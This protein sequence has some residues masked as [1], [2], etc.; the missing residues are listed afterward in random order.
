MVLT[1][2]DLAQ[3]EGITERVVTRITANL[4]TKAE[5]SDL[6]TKADLSDLVTKAELSKLATKS[7]LAAAF[8]ALGG[9]IDNLKSMLEDDQRTESQRLSRVD[10]R[11]RRLRSEFNQHV[12]AN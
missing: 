1:E 4:A 7:E 10:R 9:K 3:F 12:A 11:L 2:Q 6:A 8:A 5:L